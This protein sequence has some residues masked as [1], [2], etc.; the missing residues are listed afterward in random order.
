MHTRTNAHVFTEIQC[1][2]RKRLSLC[3]GASRG[4]REHLTPE[5]RDAVVWP[6]LWF[7][8]LKL[9]TPSSPL[10][11]SSANRPPA[12]TLSPLR[13]Y[14]PAPWSSLANCYWP[15]TGPKRHDGTGRLAAVATLRASSAVPP[16]LPGAPPF[17]HTGQIGLTEHGH[18]LQS[19]RPPHSTQRL[20]PAVYTQP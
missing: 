3:F 12:Q 5:A 10:H 15:Q 6:H 17:L 4:E 9:L 11:L 18:L 8:F 19:H 16:S 13:I 2:G 1:R 20:S 14:G 7:R